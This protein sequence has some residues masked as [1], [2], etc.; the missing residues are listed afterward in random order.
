MWQNTT[1]MGCGYCVIP[2]CYKRFLLCTYKPRGN[3]DGQALMAD[4]NYEAMQKAGDIVET[5]KK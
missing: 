1:H 2:G 4:K 5:C 3:I